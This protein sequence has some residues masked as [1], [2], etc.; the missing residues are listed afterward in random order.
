VLLTLSTTHRPATDL[1]FLLHKNPGAVRSVAVG[2]GTAHV[3]Y[4]EATEERCTATLLLEVDPIELVRGRKGSASPSAALAQYVNDRPYVASSFMSVAIAKLFGTA[5]SG[6]SAERQELADTAIPLEV[7]VPVLPSR[8]GEETLGRLFDP[9]GY[10]V[11]ASSIPLDE[12]F[13]DWGNSR[14]LDA[15]LIATCRVANVL[16]HLYVLLPVLDDDKHYWVSRDEIDKL[17]RRGEGWLGAHPERE[18]IT[19]RYLRHQGGLA[20]EALARLLEEDQPDPDMEEEQRAREEDQVEERVLLRDQRV[21]AVLAALRAAG[22][23][24]VLDLGCGDGRLLQ[25]LLKDGSFERILGVDVS[26]S[27]LERAARRLHL[28]QMSPKQRE[29][30]ELVQSS[31][32]YRDGRLEGYDAAAVVEVIEHLDPSRLGAFERTLFGVARPGTVIITTPNVE[33]NVRFD[34]LPAGSLRHRDHRFE[35]TRR[36]LGDWATRTAE[37]HGYQVRFLPVGPED[38]EVGS[39]TQMAV[40]SR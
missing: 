1:G 6:R 22:A 20:R 31:L 34:S 30:I 21:G 40:F 38:P 3:F 26:Y 4:P 23:K 5:M 32:T 12:R 37:A 8:G 35:W 10:E 27:A 7:H 36:E 19:R 18:L 2:F 9:L 15:T 39:P 14:Y 33:F 13:P 16:N 29:R 28:E 24:R 17:L 11:R 25:A